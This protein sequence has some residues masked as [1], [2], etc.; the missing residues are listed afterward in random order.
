MHSFMEWIAENSLLPS[1]QAQK[2]SRERE[3]EEVENQDEVES[4]KSC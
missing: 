3:E 4:E 2:E 1:I